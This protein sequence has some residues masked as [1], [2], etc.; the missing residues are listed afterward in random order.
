MTSKSRHRST[1]LFGLGLLIP[2]LG[3][4]NVMV[5]VEPDVAMRYL[6]IATLAVAGLFVA[7]DRERAVRPPSPRIIALL[8]FVCAWIAALS[9]RAFGPRA[10]L[11]SQGIFCA[12]ML[13]TM[14]SWKPLDEGEVRAWVIGLVAG[15]LLTAGYGQYQYWSMFPKLGPIIAAAGGSPRLYVNA[16]FY[17]SNCY[18]PFVAAVTIL[19]VGAV[20]RQGLVPRLFLSSAIVPLLITL[21]LSQSRAVLALLLAGTA[22]SAYVT[23]MLAA[24]WA[25][26][27]IL[28]IAVAGGA[29][30]AVKVSLQELWTVGWVG[31]LAI[32]VGSLR[33]I[34]E[35]WLMGVGLG[36]FW[37]YFEQYRINTYYTRYP[38]DFLLEVFAELGVVA[39][40]ALVFWL[41][42]CCADA[43]RRWR[44]VVS[45]P[46][47][48]EGRRMATA[49][50]VA[51]ALLLLHALLDIDW[52]APANPILLFAAL[53][54]AQQLDRLAR[55]E[56]FV[57]SAQPR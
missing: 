34:R 26:P 35:H 36:R 9:F 30:I 55:P 52:H 53:G 45:S 7:T 11:E 41:V 20:A 32:W 33:M 5:F 18:A 42:A 51:I 1:A 56:S 12:V 38:H 17:N 47:A 3:G 57:S 31:R 49:F 29:T 40:A 28:A 24:R 48:T 14:F 54:I 8:V 44:T 10:V 16:N 46:H 23:G 25:A 21:L 4:G 19:A 22:W 50:I 15:T 2:L 37:D 27:A 43:V 13:Y 39:G 6:T